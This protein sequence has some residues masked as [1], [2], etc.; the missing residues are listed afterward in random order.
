MMIRMHTTKQRES[1]LRLAK[2]PVRCNG[3]ESN[4]LYIFHIA[5]ALVYYFAIFFL[6]LY[7]LLYFHLIYYFRFFF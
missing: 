4:Q 5:I 2:V 3:R 7:V 6:L 1:K